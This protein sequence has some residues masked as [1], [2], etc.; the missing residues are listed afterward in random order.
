M[1]FSNHLD[2]NDQLHLTTI[3]FGPTQDHSWPQEFKRES[4]PLT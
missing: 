4:Q 2:Y 3:G 1:G